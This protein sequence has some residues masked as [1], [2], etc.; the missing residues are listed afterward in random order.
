MNILERVKRKW[1]NMEYTSQIKF[2]QNEVINNLKRIGGLELPKHKEII[3]W[4]INTFIEIKWNFPS[5][6]KGGLQA[7]KYN[8]NLKSQTKMSWVSCTWNV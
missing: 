3:P 4:R 2:K 7:K 5:P 8:L 1:Q 6:T